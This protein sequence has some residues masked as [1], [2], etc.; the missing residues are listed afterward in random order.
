MIFGYSLPIT[1][2][3]F[4]QPPGIHVPLQGAFWDFSEETPQAKK[5]AEASAEASGNGCYSW[6]LKT[7]I[8]SGFIYP[9]KIVI[10]HSK[11][12]K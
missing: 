2:F 10:V 5:S 7:V 4:L 12:N 8:Y 6:L 11:C 3:Y 1:G 9:S